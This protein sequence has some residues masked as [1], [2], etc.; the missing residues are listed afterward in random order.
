MFKQ[1]DYVTRKSYNNDIVFKILYLIENTAM[2]QGVDVR[3]LATSNINDL[4]KVEEIRNEE[5][6][7]LLPIQKG[8]YL[9]G[10]ILHLD[11]DE[12]YLKRSMKIYEAHKVPS[13]GYRID[14]KDMP[15]KI[16]ELL[17][18]HHP[19]MKVIMSKVLKKHKCGKWFSIQPVKAEN[20]YFIRK[21]QRND[22]NPTFYI[23]L[24]FGEFKDD[25]TGEHHYTRDEFIDSQHGIMDE[26]NKYCK[27]NKLDFIS[28]EINGDWTCGGVGMKIN[29]RGLKGLNE[30]TIFESIKLI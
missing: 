17:N 10:K 22:M 1:N 14:E 26:L 29:A 5:E 21:D 27:K 30:S 16:N 3:L 11:S 13:V 28:F 6:I 19:K 7:E 15:L 20:A 23:E 8:N 2:L 9:N 25:R 24:T 4:K 18:K 12:S